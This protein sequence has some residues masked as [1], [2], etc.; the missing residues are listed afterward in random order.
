MWVVRQCCDSNVEKMVQDN[1]ETELLNAVQVGA[2]TGY[3]AKRW[4]ALCADGRTPAPVRTGL[5]RGRFRWRRTEVLGWIRAG[6]P[7]RMEWEGLSR[8]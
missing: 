2:L 1:P 7:C 3:S 6:C 8:C 5:G 4:R